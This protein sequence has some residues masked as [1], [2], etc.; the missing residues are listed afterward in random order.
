M[1]INPVGE[2]EYKVFQ[3]VHSSV[4]GESCIHVKHENVKI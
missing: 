4:G 3:V 2:A 1:K